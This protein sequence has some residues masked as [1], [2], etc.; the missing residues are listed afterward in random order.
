MTVS[1]LPSAEERKWL[2]RSLRKLIERMGWERFLL[3]PIVLPSP[4]YFPDRW[5]G[6]V[7]D[8]HRLTQR[9]M[10]HAGLEG[11]SFSLAG[12]EGESDAWDSGTAGWFAGIIDGHCYFGVHVR[13]LGD[14]EAAV[15]V[16]A[17]EVAHAFRTHHNLF[18]DSRDREELLTDLTTIYLGFGVFTT[19]NTDRYRS[20]GDF[21]ETRWSVSKAGYLPPQAM[22]W[23]LA[24]QATVRGDREETKAIARDLEPNQQAWFRDA[25]REIESDPSW[26]ESLAIPA[27]RAPRWEYQLI[28]V[29]EP[30]ADDVEEPEYDDDDDPKRNEGATVAAVRRGGLVDGLLAT[31]VPGV[32]L[33][34]IVAMVAENVELGTIFAVVGVAVAG[35]SIWAVGKTRRYV[36]GFEDCETEITAGVTTC[37]GCGA[38]I[39]ARV[40]QKEMRRLL[41]EQLDREAS[42]VDF[43]DCEKCQPEKPCPR[44][45]ATVRVD[46]VSELDENL[47]A[48][49]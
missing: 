8:V 22:A 24:L 23:L 4:K 35:T 48:D 15:G 13:Q 43:P 3:A 34:L 1:S 30:D 39:S 37:P 19:N 47:S 14:P 6:S 11:L 28:D 45:K 46:N 25:L 33:A 7:A 27:K 29:I 20:S 26:L 44:H 10:A 16:M 5:G 42:S 17:H 12:F 32:L 21:N 40:S 49:G 9:L 2:G 41:E 31:V 38:T 36:C 18:T